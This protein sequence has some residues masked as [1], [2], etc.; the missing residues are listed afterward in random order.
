MYG[1][2]KEE[3]IMSEEVANKLNIAKQ[4]VA[5]ACIK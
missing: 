3:I 2:R 1:K 4:E 5:N